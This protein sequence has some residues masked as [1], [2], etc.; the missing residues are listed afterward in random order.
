MKLDPSIV[1]LKD[2]ENITDIRLRLARYST[3]SLAPSINVSERNSNSQIYF[4]KAPNAFSE[5]RPFTTW[6]FLFRSQHRYTQFFRY[7]IQQ[8]NNRH[9]DK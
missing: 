6:H 2:F 4:I 5:S 1:A 9:L 7:R 3:A 8:Q